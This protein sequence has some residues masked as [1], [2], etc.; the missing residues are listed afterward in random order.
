MLRY[1]KETFWDDMYCFSGEKFIQVYQMPA[2]VILLSEEI[3][4][5]KNMLSFL[6][7]NV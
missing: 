3:K 4:W 7:I 6:Q 5:L 2:E 1:D